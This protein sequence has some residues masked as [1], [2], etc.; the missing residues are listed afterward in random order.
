MYLFDANRHCI[1]S[2]GF[3]KKQSRLRG[4]QRNNNVRHAYLPT[5]VDPNK[6]NHTAL[7][8]REGGR[9]NDGRVVQRIEQKPAIVP[10][11]EARLHLAV[12]SV[13]QANQT[14]SL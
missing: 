12:P 13:S 8:L 11:Q 7:H 2:Y 10:C 4:F 6:Q 5:C 14:V 3:L 1:Q 9:H